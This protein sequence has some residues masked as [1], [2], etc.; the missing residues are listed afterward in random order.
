MNAS[1][2]IVPALA[3]LLAGAVRA[4]DLGRQNYIL[5]CA[6]CHQL[7]GSGAPGSGVPKIKGVLGHF[8][9]LTEG[10]EFLVQVPGSS[11]SAL[12]DLEVAELLNWMLHHFSRDE[13]PADFVPYTTDEVTR[14]RAQRLTDVTAARAGVVKKLAEMGFKAEY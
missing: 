6:G 11:N 4:A 9:R 2:L 12:N 3:M 10:R 1:I 14:L 8:P 5:H 7:D 13:L